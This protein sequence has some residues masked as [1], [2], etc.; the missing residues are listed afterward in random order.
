MRQ[1]AGSFAQYEKARL[2]AKL[3]KARARKRAANGKCEGLKSHAELNPDLVST[4]KGLRRRSPKGHRLSLTVGVCRTC[5]VGLSQHQR[6]AVCSDVHQIDIG[7]VT[8][9]AEGVDLESNI[10]RSPWSKAS[11]GLPRR[12]SSR[13]ERAD[14]AASDVALVERSKARR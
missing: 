3:A 1:I 5:P 11:R 4:A 8:A 12:Q 6:Q 10:L 9:L 13:S 14:A 2:V 7:R